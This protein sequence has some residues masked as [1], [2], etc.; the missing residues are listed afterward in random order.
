MVFFFLFLKAHSSDV[1]EMGFK[2]SAGK[3]ASL[4]CCLC[5]YMWLVYAHMHA[6]QPMV[7]IVW[8]GSFVDL[9]YMWDPLLA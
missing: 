7:S 9:M 6:S 3:N 8:E 5:R 4:C 2:R 1:L